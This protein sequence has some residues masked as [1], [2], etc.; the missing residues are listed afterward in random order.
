MLGFFI[1]E[2]EFISWSEIIFRLE[3]CLKIDS[4]FKITSLL[5]P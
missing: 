1:S 3:N 5:I 4:D 2:H